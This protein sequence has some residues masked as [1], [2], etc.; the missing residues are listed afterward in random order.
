MS[1]TLGTADHVGWYL[2]SPATPVSN[3]NYLSNDNTNNIPS[4]FTSTFQQ[5]IL[6]NLKVVTSPTDPKGLTF[7]S[8]IYYFDHT[9]NDATGTAVTDAVDGTGWSPSA[10]FM[11]N[12]WS[13]KV[14]SDKNWG[15]GNNI[16]PIGGK[17]VMPNP[18]TFNDITLDMRFGYWVYIVKNST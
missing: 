15:T 13:V 12:N 11:Q 3:K 4:E 14:I 5:M 9:K 6:D 16:Q 8:T 2:L 17:N 7:G 10:N 18:S 1:I